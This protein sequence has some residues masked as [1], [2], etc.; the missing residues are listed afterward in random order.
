MLKLSKRIQ[1]AREA[2]G[3]SISELAPRMGKA[4]STVAS[5]E[6]GG[7]DSCNTASLKLVARALDLNTD[8][9]LAWLAFGAGP[10]PMILPV[11]KGGAS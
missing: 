10:V 8:R 5:L 6:L 7:V 4:R 1:K 9:Q 2:R 3:L 11:E